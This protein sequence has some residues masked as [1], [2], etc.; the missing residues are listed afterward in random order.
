MYSNDIQKNRLKYSEKYNYYYQ[1]SIVNQSI[2]LKINPNVL[3][4]QEV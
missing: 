2:K 4:Y 1:N 3:I